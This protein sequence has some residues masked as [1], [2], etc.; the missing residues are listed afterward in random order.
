MTLKCKKTFKISLWTFLYEKISNEEWVHGGHIQYLL[1]IVIKGSSRWKILQRMT[2]LNKLSTNTFNFTCYKREL[3]ESETLSLLVTVT[4]NS[5]YLRVTKPRKCHEDLRNL[6]SFL[7]SYLIF[8]FVNWYWAS[9]GIQVNN[10]S[11]EPN[12]DQLAWWRKTTPRS[13]VEHF[14]AD[15]A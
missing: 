2:N 9:I 14:L 7:I 4:T 15:S 5:H 13:H 12:L 6:K 3:Q 1:S 10:F 11:T 8:L